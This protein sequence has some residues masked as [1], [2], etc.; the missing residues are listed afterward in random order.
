MGTRTVGPHAW[1]TQAVVEGSAAVR[2]PAPCCVRGQS[3]WLP[4]FS[5]VV[6]PPRVIRHRE[7]TGAATMVVAGAANVAIAD[8][9]Q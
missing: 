7:G 2:A 8:L 6:G 1:P 9:H 5:E 3:S 4:R